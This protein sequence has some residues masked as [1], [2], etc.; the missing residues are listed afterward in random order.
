MTKTWGWLYAGPLTFPKMIL[1]SVNRYPSSFVENL[2]NICSWDMELNDP[3]FTAKLKASIDGKGM[4]NP[5]LVMSL[6]GYLS[7]EQDPAN[8]KHIDPAKQ[9]ICMIGNNRYQYALLHGY[10]HIEC[11][12]IDD[13]V[14]L[15]RMTDLML[16]K[17]RKM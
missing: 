14:E 4:L 6:E 15:R 12:L 13:P 10:T 16:I 9:Y 5:I 3:A 17:P 2:Q 8:D 7:S 1:H 11:L